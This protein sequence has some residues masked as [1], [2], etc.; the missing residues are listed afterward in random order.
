MNLLVSVLVLVFL[1]VFMFVLVQV[2]VLVF[3]LMFVLARATTCTRISA[4]VNSCALLLKQVLILGLAPVLVP[5]CGPVLHNVYKPCTYNRFLFF[6]LWVF[7]LYLF[8]ALNFCLCLYCCHCLYF[9]FFFRLTPVVPFISNIGT[10]TST[11][12]I[13]FKPCGEPNLSREPTSAVR[14]SLLLNTRVFF[15]NESYNI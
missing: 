2:I 10:T 5:Q 12:L 14:L 1:I 15:R 13:L 8:L 9:N 4:H 3:V 11:R 7:F 6:F